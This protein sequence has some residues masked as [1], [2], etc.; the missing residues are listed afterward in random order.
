MYHNSVTKEKNKICLQTYL[1][2]I[3][4]W[5]VLENNKGTFF[6]KK[7]LDNFFCRY[8]PILDTVMDYMLYFI[9][10]GMSVKFNNSSLKPTFFFSSLNQ[11]I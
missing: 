8:L 3:F 7:K 2:V 6:L 5:Y 9:F 4:E 10:S 11:S 1:Y